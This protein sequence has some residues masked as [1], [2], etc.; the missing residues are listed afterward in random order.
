MKMDAWAYRLAS[1]F[2]HP[3][4]AGAAIIQARAF[5]AWVACH[6]CLRLCAAIKTNAEYTLYF[7]ASEN[8]DV[9]IAVS[10]ARP[11]PRLSC[12]SILALSS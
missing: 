6:R 8:G 9:I 4:Q 5:N 12:P 1:T 11:Y 3:L 7:T 2:R 10:R